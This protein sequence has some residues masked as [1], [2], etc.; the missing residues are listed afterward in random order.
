LSLTVAKRLRALLLVLSI[1]WCWVYKIEKASLVAHRSSPNAID[2]DQ[3]IDVMHTTSA[4]E[5]ALTQIAAPQKGP[6]I[7][8]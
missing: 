7:E 8:G 4:A 3:A 5:A 2:N 6:L 1:F